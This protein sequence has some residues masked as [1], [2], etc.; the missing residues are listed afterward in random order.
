MLVREKLSY[1]YYI[2]WEPKSNMYNKT[3]KDITNDLLIK[4]YNEY[5]VKLSE[6]IKELNKIKKN[7]KN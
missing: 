4:M 1:D 5:I 2:N 3:D 7:I 6:F